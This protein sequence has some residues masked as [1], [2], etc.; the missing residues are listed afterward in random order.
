MIQRPCINHWCPRMAGSTPRCTQCQQEQDRKRNAQPKRKAYRQGGYRSYPVAG[1]LCAL[2]YR[3]IC[4]KYATTRD[5]IVPLSR[6]GSNDWSN[7][8]PAC[9]EC[10]SAKRDR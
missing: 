3:F 1:R 2:R 5:H 4:T 8:Q 10:N 6:G 7:L 9:R